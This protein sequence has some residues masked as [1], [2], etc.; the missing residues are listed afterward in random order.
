MD[1]RLNKKLAYPEYTTFVSHRLNKPPVNGDN[2]PDGT[3]YQ[4]EVVEDGIVCVRVRFSDGTQKTYPLSPDGMS[5]ELTPS[6]IDDSYEFTPSD[7]VNN[8]LQLDSQYV[9]ADI[10]FYTD[11]SKDESQIVSMPTLL[12]STGTVIDFSQVD[13]EDYQYG[14]KVRFSRGVVYLF[15]EDTVRTASGAS[16]QYAMDASL[17][18][19]HILSSIGGELYLN[20]ANVSNLP[21]N[22][23]LKIVVDNSSSNHDVYVE[24]GIVSHDK[25]FVCYMNLN[26]TIVQMGS[27]IRID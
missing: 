20:K 27:V 18:Y 9:I 7:V 11:I 17:G 19:T 8:K 15:S 2:P 14:G 16:G 4:W 12:T 21:A 13:Q 6:E 23:L 22:K 24:G 25:F 10:S 1:S 3:V 5:S 26:G